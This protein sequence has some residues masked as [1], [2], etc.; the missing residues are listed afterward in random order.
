MR[1]VGA[2]PSSKTCS[3][4]WFGFCL[5]SAARNGHTSIALLPPPSVSLKQLLLLR[6]M[7]RARKASVLL[8][9][10][11]CSAA[12]VR[13]RFWCSFCHRRAMAQGHGARTPLTGSPTGGAVPTVGAIGSLACNLCCVDDVLLVGSCA[14]KTPCMPFARPHVTRLRFGPVGDS[15]CRP[16]DSGLR[17]VCQLARVELLEPR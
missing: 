15:C 6:G 7:A 8:A 11:Q 16:A 10:A 3:T 14:R 12:A 1:A 9:A 13:C 17:P 5:H 2:G 4:N